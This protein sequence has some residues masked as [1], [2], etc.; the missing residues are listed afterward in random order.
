MGTGCD[1]ALK[2]CVFLSRLSHSQGS[3]RR[4]NPSDPQ[5]VFTSVSSTIYS[6]L[7]YDDLLIWL[8][9]RRAEIKSDRRLVPEMS[10]I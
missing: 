3:W 5:T 6:Q 10:E 7:S 9:R 1:P 2:M 4:L 8:Q